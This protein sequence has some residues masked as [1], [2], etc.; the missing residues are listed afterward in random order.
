ML[1]SFFIFVVVTVLCGVVTAKDERQL[2]TSID[3]TACREGSQ[4][5]VMVMVP[6]L[7]QA[8]VDMPL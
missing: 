4:G 2:T 5:P 8:M 3:S 7:M 6:A 1:V